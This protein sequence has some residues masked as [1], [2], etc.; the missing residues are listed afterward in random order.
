MVFVEK[1]GVQRKSACICV[2]NDSKN[3]QRN[4][5]DVVQYVK[6]VENEGE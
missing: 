6:T 5:D 2:Q 3:T 4:R 1:I